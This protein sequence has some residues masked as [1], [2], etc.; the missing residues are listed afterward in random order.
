MD[1]KYTFDDLYDIMRTLRSEKGCPWD[2]KQTNESIIPCLKEEAGEVIQAIHNQDEENLCEELGDL[3]YQ[4]MILSQI[5]E[6]KGTFTIRDV[7]DGISAKMIRRH[8]NVFGDVKVESFEEGMD[9]WNKMKTEEK[10]KKV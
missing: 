2:R 4:I 9:L 6:E 8:P 3:L 1:N 10:R 7:V 5:A